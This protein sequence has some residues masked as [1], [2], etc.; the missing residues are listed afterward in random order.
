MKHQILFTGLA[1]T[2]VA[3]PACAQQSE[4]PNIVLI[5]VDDMGY[6]DL[7]CYG[8]EISTPNLDQLAENGLRMTQFYNTARSC[9]T[10]ASLLTGLTPHQAG[11]G[12]MVDRNL[13]YEGYVGNLTE[14]SITLPEVLK[15]VGYDTYM[16]GKWHVV[17]S[18]NAKHGS[19][20][21]S[22]WPRQ[23]GFDRF[24][25]IVGG[26]AHYWKPVNISLDNEKYPGEPYFVTDMIG[27]YACSFLN[28]HKAKQNDHPFFLYLAYNAPHWPLHARPETID[29]YMDYYECGWDEARARR[30]EKMKQLG[31]IDPRWELT[32]RDSSAVPWD[33]LNSTKK[34]E[35]VKRM[36]TYAAMVDEMDQS[37]GKV[38]ATLKENGQDK[39]TLIMFL[40]DN[41]ACAEYITN[42]PDRSVE[43]IGTA[44]SY[45]S[46]R[47]PWANVSVTPFRLYKHWMHEGGISTPFIVNW[48]GLKNPGRLDHTPATLI[49]IM[50]TFVDVSG[51]TYPGAPVPAMEGKSLLPIFKGGTLEERY[52]FLEHEANRMARKGKWKLVEKAS[53]DYP[54]VKKWELYDMEA[55]RTEMHNLADQYP[56]IVKEMGDQWQHW[57]ETHKVLPLDGRIHGER[58]KN[59]IFNFPK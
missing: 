42:G 31:I 11:V 7:G 29:R 54:F 25:G 22:Q 50:A 10:R 18:K 9:P 41:G 43:A 49:D 13:G 28:E 38:L 14:N 58:I 53:Y 55:D 45:E 6:S 26:A 12:W 56:E 48:D 20:D 19:Q 46:Y 1:A 17:S 36:A 35:M 51:A 5:L 39:N 30:Y 59:P 34:A 24:F 3:A 32:P 52:I 27:D 37:V 33:S 47:L 4:R 44:N 15:T 21:K 57:A 2:M 16:S 40:A 23:R 8:S